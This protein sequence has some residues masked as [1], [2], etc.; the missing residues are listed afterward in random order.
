MVGSLS[1]L[2]TVILPLRSY[3]NTNVVSIIIDKN[4]SMNTVHFYFT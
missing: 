4:P 2:D 1:Q 3:Q